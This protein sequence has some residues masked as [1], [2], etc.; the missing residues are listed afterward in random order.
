MI[1]G[2]KAVPLAEGFE[3]ILI[4]GERRQMKAQTRVKEGI[5]VSENL[6]KEFNELAGELGVQPLEAC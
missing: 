6:L 1:R 3:C 2:I 5:P 4:P